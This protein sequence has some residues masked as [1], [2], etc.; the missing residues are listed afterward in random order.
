ELL[1][2]LGLCTVENVLWLVKYSNPHDALSLDQ[3]HTVHGSLGGKHLL[4][5]L[6]TIISNLGCEGMELVKKQVTEFP[7]W[8]NLNHFATIIHI[9][10]T[11]GNKK[12]DLILQTFYVALNALDYRS[13]LEGYC[14]LHVICSYLKLDSLIRLDVHMEWTIVMIEDELL[15]FGTTL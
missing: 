4:A 8:C 10:F 5:E 12:C 15:V 7:Q 11:D 3:L 13:C 6:K 2:P 9:T 14:L 1:K